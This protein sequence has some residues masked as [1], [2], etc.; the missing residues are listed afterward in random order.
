MGLP[1]NNETKDG[2]KV[3]ADSTWGDNRTLEEITGMGYTTDARNATARSHPEQS[4]SPAA[5]PS[6]AGEL[7]VGRR[8]SVHTSPSSNSIYR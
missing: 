8:T 5:V 6:S 3:F 2:R 1:V 4:Q 7:W